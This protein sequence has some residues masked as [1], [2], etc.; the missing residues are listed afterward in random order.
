MSPVFAGLPSNYDF[1]SP[2]VTLALFRKELRAVNE[3]GMVAI[4]KR[5]FSLNL[6]TP[7]KRQTLNHPS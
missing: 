7:I 5:Y 3:R 1:H 2:G 4:A 6:Q